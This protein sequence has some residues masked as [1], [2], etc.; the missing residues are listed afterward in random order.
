MNANMTLPYRKNDTG[1]ISGVHRWVH[2]RE[3]YTR[4]NEKKDEEK[5]KKL[6]KQHKIRYTTV[7]SVN[8]TCLWQ[9][10]LLANFPRFV[11]TTNRARAESKKFDK[12]CCCCCC[13][14]CCYLHMYLKHSRGEETPWPKVKLHYIQRYNDAHIILSQLWCITD[15]FLLVLRLMLAYS[16]RLIK[17]WCATD[18]CP[19]SVHR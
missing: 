9:S 18:I 10:Q 8:K 12:C 5:G 7:V 1:T 2:L 11:P 4:I 3:I 15:F 14:C 16:F 6:K 19:Q 17:E 13:C